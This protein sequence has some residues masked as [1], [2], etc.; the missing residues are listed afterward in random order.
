MDSIDVTESVGVSSVAI[1]DNNGLELITTISMAMYMG[2]MT[3][4]D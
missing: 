3:L 4:G 2:I 1:T